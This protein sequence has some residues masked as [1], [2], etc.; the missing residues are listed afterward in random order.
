MFKGLKLYTDFKNTCILGS[1][2]DSSDSWRYMNRVG[3]LSRQII[4]REEQR[5][6]RAASQRNIISNAYWWLRKNTLSLLNLSL[7][8]L[9]CCGGGDKDLQ[10]LSYDQGSVA[11]TLTSDTSPAFPCAPE[12][13][14]LG[15]CR[16]VVGCSD[17]GPC[18]AGW[19]HQWQGP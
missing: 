5:M 19:V 12:L 2:Q 3:K 9:P 7:T 16:F 6:L 13:D 10:W 14:L 8:C 18:L 1:H 11:G 17:P 15:G 4:W